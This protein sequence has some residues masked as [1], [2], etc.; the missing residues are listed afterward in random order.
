MTTST[1]FNKHCDASILR[2]YRIESG[3]QSVDELATSMASDMR[4][5][6]FETSGPGTGSSEHA[7]TEEAKPQEQ[8]L[9]EDEVEAEFFE[10]PTQENQAEK[11]M[12]REEIENTLKQTHE[13]LAPFIERNQGPSSQSSS[14]ERPSPVQVPIEDQET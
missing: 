7:A 9:N 2:Q 5:N 3:H 1:Y 4:E 11:Q 13:L 12:E 6:H 10:F 8:F 14:F